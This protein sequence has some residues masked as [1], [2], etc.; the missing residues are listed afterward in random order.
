MWLTR[1]DAVARRD[2]MVRG[3]LTRADDAALRFD[4]LLH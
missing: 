3:T 1:A 4:G 2:A